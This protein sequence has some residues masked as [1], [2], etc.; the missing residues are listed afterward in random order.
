MQAPAGKASALD[1]NCLR[2]S[3]MWGV[4]I[5]SDGE[6]KRS[7][8]GVA[9]DINIKQKCASARRPVIAA[10]AY[11]SVTERPWWNSSL[12]QPGSTDARFANG[13][14]GTHPAK[15]RS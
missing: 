12:P 7:I 9:G 1:G 14:R 2:L 10:G 3:V 13:H 11:R 6:K 8:A 4:A 15:Q 5:H